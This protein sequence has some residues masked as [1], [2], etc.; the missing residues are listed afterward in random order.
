MLLATAERKHLLR[1]LLPEQYWPSGHDT[2]LEAEIN[3]LIPMESLTAATEKKLVSMGSRPR[4]HPSKSQISVGM[5]YRHIEIGKPPGDAFVPIDGASESQKKF[6][7][8]WMLLKEHLVEPFRTGKWNHDLVRKWAEND[9]KT[10]LP[11]FP[12]N[13]LVT[14]LR[15]LSTLLSWD[16]RGVFFALAVMISW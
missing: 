14:G 8:A 11:L 6:V 2:T 4:G 9:V 5:M 15:S 1:T 12:C 13:G 3:N 7:E 16:W 10:R